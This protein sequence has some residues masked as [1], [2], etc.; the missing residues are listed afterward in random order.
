MRCRRTD[1]GMA[2]AVALLAGSTMSAAQGADTA[3]IRATVTDATGAVTARG[4]GHDD[5]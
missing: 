5:Q 2:F 3:L 4:A 1:P